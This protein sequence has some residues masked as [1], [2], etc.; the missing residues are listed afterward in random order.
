MAL[1][2]VALEPVNHTG[3]GDA[4]REPILYILLQCDVEL[5]GKLLLLFRYVFPAIEFHL[6][7]ELSDQ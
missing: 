6:K 7:G 1:G 3:L 2:L 4:E 5:G